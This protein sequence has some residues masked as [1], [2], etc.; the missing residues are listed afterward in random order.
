MDKDIK[1]LYEKLLKHSKVDAVYAYAPGRINLIGEHT[2]YNGG[3]VFPAAI[4]LGIMTSVSKNRTNQV[5]VMSLN[6]DNYFEFNLN[7]VNTVKYDGWQNYVG[8]VVS[9]LIKHGYSLEGFN[10]CITGNIPIGSGLS[11]SAA[12]ENSIVIALNKLF[13]LGLSKHEMVA[14]SQKA[15]HDFVGVN[16]GIMDQYGSMFGKSDNA[17]LLQCS[18][19]E[20]TF[21]PVD[22]EEYELVLINS[23]VNHSLGDSEYNVRRKTCER[24]ASKFG[25]KYVSEL[26]SSVLLAKKSELTKNEFQRANFVIEE[27]K[28]VLSA[29]TA[30]QEKD[31][32]TF[33]KL[34]YESHA[35]LQFEYEVSCKELDF[36]V[37]SARS[38]GE[39]LGARMMGGGFGGCSLNLINKESKMFKES[40]TRTYLKKFNKKLSFIAVKLDNGARI[41]NDE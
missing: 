38:S 23:H 13:S 30:L 20:S 36:L 25:V 21:L 40:I 32:K 33:G 17:F 35:G 16:C 5:K 11:S 24:V 34:L 1:S 9:Q 18:S 27:N 8:G 4:N 2:D 15:E 41:I 6:M 14:I 29:F 3:Y 12:L 39:V 7:T 26:K 19:L 10:L 28:R 22:F 37:E 31:L